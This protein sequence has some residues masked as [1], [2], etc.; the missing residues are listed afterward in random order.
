MLF[1]VCSFLYNKIEQFSFVEVLLSPKNF[2]LRNVPD[3]T[4][5]GYYKFWYVRKFKKEVQ[6]VY[7]SLFLV[8]CYLLHIPRLLSSQLATWEVE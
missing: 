3:T 5:K 1:A 4:T 7:S 8:N 6:K 2:N